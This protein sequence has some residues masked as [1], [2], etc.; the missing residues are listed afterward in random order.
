[1]DSLIN[2]IKNKC[3]FTL[4]EVLI[5][6]GIIG[7]VAALTLPVLIQVNKNKEVETKLKKIYSVMNQAILISETANGPKEY[8]TWT[9]GG[10]FMEKYIFPYMVSSYKI[11]N[12]TPETNPDAESSSVATLENLIVYFSDGTV[13]VAKSPKAGYTATLIPRYSV[14]FYFYPNGRNFSKNDFLSKNEDG[15]IARKDLGISFFAF[16][17]S[18]AG[19]GDTNNKFHEKKGF[20]PYM[21]GLTSLSEDE[22]C[23]TGL[24]AC[25]KEGGNRG[26]CTEYIR[27][28]NWQIPKDY[29]F[30]VR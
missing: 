30:K 1:M 25:S 16:R 13:L 28:N 20:E 8:W 19:F 15:T 5:T 21:W 2:K 6:L 11:E 23:R 10:N 14:D 12:Y 24:F 7:I 9:S 27:M 18:P 3:A 17:F 4:A 26:Y 29:P 22:I